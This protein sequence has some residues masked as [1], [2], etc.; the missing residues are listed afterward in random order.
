ML[1]FD[2]RCHKC[3]TCVIYPHRSMSR[4]CYVRECCYKKLD[5]LT[6]LLLLQIYH[7]R[8]ST[9]SSTSNRTVG[10]SNFL[11]RRTAHAYHV[12]VTL[13]YVD[14]LCHVFVTLVL[15]GLTSL[16]VFFSLCFFP[17]LPS[18]HLPPL[19]LS[20]PPSL[21]PLTLPLPLP[22][23]LSPCLPPSL[24]SLLSLSR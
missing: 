17:S 12:F 4:I 13:V 24:L 1:T 21:P 18:T 10:V 19:S 16:L 7:S 23:S 11:W 5:S 20:L 2:D 8:S 3:V 22:L 6:V 9:V 15:K 14:K